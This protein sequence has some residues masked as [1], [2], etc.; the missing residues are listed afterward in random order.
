MKKFVVMIALVALVGLGGQ[1]AAEIGTIDNVPAATLL[2]PYFEVG[3]GTTSGLTTLFSVNNASAAPTVAHVTIWSEFTVP[4]IDFDIYLTGYDVQTVNLADLILN[5]VLPRT[6]PSNTVSNNGA[7]SNPHSTFGGTCSAVAGA[8]PNYNPISASFR[9]LIQ[10]SLSG[11]PLSVGPQAGRCASLPGNTTIARGYVTIDNA[12]ECS[13]L[14]PGDP[15]YF[16]DGG[17]GVANDDN[18]LWGDYF[19]VNSTQNFAQGFTLVHVE[20]DIT[21]T[22]PVV[23]VTPQTFYCRYALGADDREALGSKYAVRFLN[24]GAFTGGTDV[25]SYRDPGSAGATRICSSAG[26]SLF[27]QA[28][29]VVFDEQENPITV[30]LGGASGEPLPSAQRPFPFEANRSEVG[31]DLSVDVYTFGWLWLN[32]N[33]TLA[34]S[35]AEKNQAYVS[36]VMDAEGRFSVGVDAIQLNN[37]TVADLQIVAPGP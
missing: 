12:S 10:E 8:I 25:L 16:V 36:A 29:I 20:A 9:Q 22:C 34:G 32:L 3:L 15:G 37:L 31:V 23:D 5:G 2:L 18:V 28:A 7:F 33:G 14:F 27:S 11:Q 35:E 21:L 13:Q 1:A 30:T 26:A 4:I 24:G 6:G 19:I 17:L